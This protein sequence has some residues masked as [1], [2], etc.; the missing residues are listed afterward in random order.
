M[1]GDERIALIGPDFQKL[2]DNVSCLGSLYGYNCLFKRCATTH[3]D[4]PAIAEDVAAGIVAV[5]AS[6]FIRSGIMSHITKECPMSISH[7]LSALHY[8]FIPFIK[9]GIPSCNSIA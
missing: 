2:K 6:V 1:V 8:Y 7:R 5:P 3:V 9:L 4:T